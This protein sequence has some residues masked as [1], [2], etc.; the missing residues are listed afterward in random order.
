MASTILAQGRPLMPWSTKPGCLRGNKKEKGKG[1]KEGNG[2]DTG[3]F[4]HRAPRRE[5]RSFFSQIRGERERG[6]FISGLHGAP[7]ET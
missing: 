3:A 7:W 1:E 4:L 2:T 6:D 5:S